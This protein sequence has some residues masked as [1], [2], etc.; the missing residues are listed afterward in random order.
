MQSI[1]NKP[2]DGEKYSAERSRERAAGESSPGSVRIH[3]RGAGDDPDGSARYAANEGRRRRRTKVA[4]REQ[5]SRPYEE[6][7]EFFFA[8]VFVVKFPPE[9]AYAKE[10]EV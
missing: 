6:G 8:F 3:S 10:E 5:R 7:R 2:D 9:I 1:E 4:P